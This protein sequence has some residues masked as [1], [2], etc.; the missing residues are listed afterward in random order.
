[1]GKILVIVLF[2][3]FTLLFAPTAFAI[4]TNS[5]VTIVNPQRLANY[6]KD[7][8]TSFEA[9]Y[10]EVRERNLPAT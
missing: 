1:M 10:R 2:L 8:L 6:T 3:L 7:Y 9:E 4:D 5:F